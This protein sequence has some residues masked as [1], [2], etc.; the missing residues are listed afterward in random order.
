MCAVRK[1]MN[2]NRESIDVGSIAPGYNEVI[3]IE[4]STHGNYGF[5][6]NIA[7]QSHRTIPKRAYD[8]IAARLLMM[9][10]TP[11]KLDVAQIVQSSSSHSCLPSTPECFGSLAYRAWCLC[12]SSSSGIPCQADCRGPSRCRVPHRH[13][14]RPVAIFLRN[15]EAMQATTT[16]SEITAMD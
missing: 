16:L 3:D 10:I 2:G 9:K 13:L 15:R 7:V 14:A 4:S 5:L 11:R 6:T 1:L 8:N 12:S